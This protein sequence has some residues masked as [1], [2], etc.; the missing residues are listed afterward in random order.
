VNTSKIFSSSISQKLQGNTGKRSKNS[1]SHH[2]AASRTS[3]NR[4][5][6]MCLQ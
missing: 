4:G 1:T 2:A 6:R 5:P 3:V